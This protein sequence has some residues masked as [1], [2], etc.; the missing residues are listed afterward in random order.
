MY[1]MLAHLVHG[2]VG[3]DP[4]VLKQDVRTGSHRRVFLEAL[5]EERLQLRRRVLRERRRSSLDN[6][7]HD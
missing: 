4:R 1:L 6:P 3:S 5:R 7:V 2:E